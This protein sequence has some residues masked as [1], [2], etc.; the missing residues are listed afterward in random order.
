MWGVGLRVQGLG[1]GFIECERSSSS[2]IASCARMTAERQRG[3]KEEAEEGEGE[4]EAVRERERDRERERKQER[5]RRKEGGGRFG[6]AM[7]VYC[8]A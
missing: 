4:R 3:R 5:K 7:C 2:C 6:R 1:V 8:G